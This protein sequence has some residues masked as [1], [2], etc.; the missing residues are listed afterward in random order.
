ML[1]PMHTRLVLGRIVLRV[2]RRKLR[3]HFVEPPFQAQPQLLGGVAPVAQDVMPLSGI[4]TQI[5]Q[6][7][8]TVFVVVNQLPWPASDDR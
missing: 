6:L 7:V 8:V 2:G 1:E 3:L 4:G 5:I